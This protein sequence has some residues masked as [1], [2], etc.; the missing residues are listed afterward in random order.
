MSIN[1]S[2]KW[3]FAD[4][5]P[6][7][8]L[9]EIEPLSV[10]AQALLARSEST[11]LHEAFIQVMGAVQM[12]SGLDYHFQQFT[13]ALR[14]DGTILPRDFSAIRHEAIAWINRLGQFH[15]FARSKLLIGH[16]NGGVTPT[17]DSL[18]LFR[19][20]H[21]AHR[22]IDKPRPEDSQSLQI[23]HAIAMTDLSGTLWIPRPPFTPAESPLPSVATHFLA[24][25]LQ[26]SEGVPRALV[27]ERDHPVVM[28]EAY[29]LVERLL[30]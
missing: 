11:V 1:D 25:Q 7:F 14:R 26:A 10:R 27:I 22:S 8:E 19:N 9:D 18:M 13:A 12:L 20:K 29:A 23:S 17:I 2:R 15:F 24:F 21:A 30:Q 3:Y 16:V 4:P 6:E 28:K 5:R